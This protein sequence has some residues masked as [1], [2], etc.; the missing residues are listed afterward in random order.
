MLQDEWIQ[1]VALGL[2]QMIELPEVLAWHRRHGASVTSEDR[3]HH[4]K[5]NIGRSLHTSN[6]VYA[7]RAA[8]AESYAEWWENSVALMLLTHG[9]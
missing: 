3:G 6:G 5:Y 8:L 9:K 2:G 7:Q 4:L 1:F